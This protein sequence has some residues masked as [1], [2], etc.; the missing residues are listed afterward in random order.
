MRSARCSSGAEMERLIWM[1]A[2]DDHDAGDHH[3]KHDE[4]ERLPVSD[5]ET[6]ARGLRVGDGLVG[7]L[8]ERVAR[9]IIGAARDVPR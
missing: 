5:A 4:P 6:V 8:A 1:S 2:G 3:A 9:R 7:Q